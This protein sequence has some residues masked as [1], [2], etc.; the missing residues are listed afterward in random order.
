[1][2]LVHPGIERRGRQGNHRSRVR[3]GLAAGAKGI[4]TLG[5]TSSVSLLSRSAGS[6]DARSKACNIN[7]GRR[8]S[9]R[10]L[11]MPAMRP[12][13]LKSEKADRVTNRHRG[14]RSLR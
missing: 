13:K 14:D 9:G 5:P 11:A 7:P 3:N 6:I 12:A 10:R 1:L 8:A 4:R 2:L